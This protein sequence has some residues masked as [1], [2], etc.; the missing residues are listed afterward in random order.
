MWHDR[1]TETYTLGWDLTTRVP[2]HHQ[3]K[4]GIDATY[5]NA[6]YIIIRRPWVEDPV[7]LDEFHDL[8]H[9]YPNRGAAYAY[10]GK[11]EEAKKDL[12]EGAKLDPALKPLIKKISD[13]FKL[14]L[15][16]D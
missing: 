6:Q 14:N 5:E 11:T 4:T 12:L 7:G 13:R 1:Y 8:F 3:V 16:L 9:I 15:K 10:S 2:P